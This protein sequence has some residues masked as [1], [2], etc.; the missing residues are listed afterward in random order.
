[1][2]NLKSLLALMFTVVLFA[3]AVVAQQHSLNDVHPDDK[4]ISSEDGFEIALPA[5]WVKQERLATGRRYTWQVT[6]GAVSVTIRQFAAANIIKSDDDIVAFLHGY[7]EALKSDPGVHFI[8]TTRVKIGEYK[9]EA[10][11]ISVDGQPSLFVVLAWGKFN[12][13]LN[14]TANAKIAGSDKLI[15]A[16]VHT[17]EFNH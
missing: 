11:E 8:S 14:G 16:A 15:F 3:G 4:F 13:V 1:M 5:G 10:Y 2:K 9:G 12:L 6:E 17:F 7:S